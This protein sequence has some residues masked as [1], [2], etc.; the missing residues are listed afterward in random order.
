MPRRWASNRASTSVGTLAGRAR[1]ACRT[2]GVAPRGCE[3]GALREGS[4][5]ADTEFDG[6]LA[7]ARKY[8]SA[9]SYDV[10]RMP[11]DARDRQALH[12]V[13]LAL[14]AMLAALEDADGGRDGTRA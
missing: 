12:S 10:Q 3:G 6:Y 9:A 4:V 11:D 5:V 2:G 13:V 14:D 7:E 1:L 8:I